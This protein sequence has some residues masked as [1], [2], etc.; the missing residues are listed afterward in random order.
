MLDNFMAIRAPPKSIYLFSYIG[1]RSLPLRRMSD[2]QSTPRYSDNIGKYITRT[3]IASDTAFKDEFLDRF[4][5]I[6][7]S[8]FISAET[9][10]R[11]LSCRMTIAR[12]AM[13]RLEA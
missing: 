12:R 6:G 8:Y 2:K 5:P 1:H 11:V 10:C 9:S 7:S 3:M 13:A 4:R